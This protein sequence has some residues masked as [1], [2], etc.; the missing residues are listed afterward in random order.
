MST[1]KKSAM[2]ETV[3]TSSKLQIARLRA[4]AGLESDARTEKVVDISRRPIAAKLMVLAS[5][6]VAEEVSRA[7][8]AVWKA[9]HG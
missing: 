9:G 3:Q 7:H 4:H 1:I 8:A 5:L 2:T 6:A